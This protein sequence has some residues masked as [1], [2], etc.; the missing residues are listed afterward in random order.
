MTWRKEPP[1]HAEVRDLTPFWW[2]RMP[3]GTTHVL[4]LEASIGSD[5]II[6]VLEQAS[7]DCGGRFDPSDWPGEWTPCLPPL[8][9]VKA[10]TAQEVED[11]SPLVE[12]VAACEALTELE[13]TPDAHEEQRCESADYVDGWNDAITEIK[14]AL[15]KVHAVG[16]GHLD[17]NVRTRSGAPRRRAASC[18]VATEDEGDHG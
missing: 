16:Q 1:T 14:A 15:A 17:L 18:M 7:S 13:W 10:M 8:G 6:D 12:M 9:E 11:A 5:A 2:H 3:D 4:H